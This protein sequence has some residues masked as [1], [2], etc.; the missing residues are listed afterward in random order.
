M[1]SSAASSLSGT[2]SSNSPSKRLLFDRRYGWVFCI[3]PLAKTL[4]KMASQSINAAANS[5]VK[6]FERPDLLSPQQLQ[7]GLYNE[8]HK[9]KSSLVKP[10]FNHLLLKG[11]LSSK[12]A[13]CSSS[14]S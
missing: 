8:L 5:A 12:E 3:L 10:E 13:S 14:K 4:I 1:E 6:A 11:N 9:I 7:A 2:A